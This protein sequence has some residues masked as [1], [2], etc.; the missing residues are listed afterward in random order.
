[1]IARCA[2]S[3]QPVK[4]QPMCAHA[5]IRTHSAGLCRLA[6]H[7][8]STA[9]LQRLGTRNGKTG[10]VTHPMT[11]RT[12]LR[13]SVQV[14][15]HVHTPLR[16]HVRCT[17]TGNCA[18]PAIQRSNY[19]AV[20]GDVAYTTLSLVHSHARMHPFTRALRQKKC[21]RSHRES[22]QFDQCA[23]LT[24]QHGSKLCRHANL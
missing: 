13:H 14:P 3:N 16:V 10:T 7:H 6:Y 8:A 20:D 9:V 24:L 4:P 1:M 15:M 17:T 19:C 21:A 12:D 23:A 2:R 11:A 5:A 18:L 22:D